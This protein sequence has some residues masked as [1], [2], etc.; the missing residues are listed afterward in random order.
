MAVTRRHGRLG[1]HAD[2]VVVEGSLLASLVG[3]NHRVSR[4][5]TRMVF[6]GCGREI[7]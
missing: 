3:F 6:E 5:R 4:T 2:G 7:E 1:V